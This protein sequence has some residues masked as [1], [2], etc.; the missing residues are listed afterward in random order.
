[1]ILGRGCT[2]MDN[3]KRDIE[4]RWSCKPCG[5]TSQHNIASL[6]SGSSGFANPADYRAPNIGKKPENMGGG[7][8]IEL[9]NY[10][11]I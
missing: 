9:E 6:R 3:S 10:P 5:L 1:M 2:L 7:Y 8:S 4:I 11:W